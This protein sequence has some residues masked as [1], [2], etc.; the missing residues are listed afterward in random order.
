MLGFRELG[1]SPVVS[2]VPVNDLELPTAEY[3]RDKAAEIRFV[4]RLVNSPEVG[5]SCSNSLTFSIAWQPTRRDGRL[6][7]IGF[8]K[9]SDVRDPRIAIPYRE[10]GRF[11]PLGSISEDIHDQG[12]V[13]RL[14]RE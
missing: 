11:G 2:G 6:A 13:A 3:Y 7:P 9:K 14:L 10:Y 12:T 4:A 5:V 8:P 1:E